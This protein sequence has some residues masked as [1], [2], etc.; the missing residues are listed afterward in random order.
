M[1]GVAAR[2]YGARRLTCDVDCLP[3]AS[4]ENLDRL[5][6]AMRELNARLRVERLGDEEWALLPI[7]LTGS[8]LIRLEIS[9]WR[10]DAGDL[11]ILADIP[12]PQGRHLAYEDLRAGA[13]ELNLHGT[14]VRVAALDDVIASKEWSNRPKDGDALPELRALRPE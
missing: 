12:G 10:T 7:R 13:S 5:A 6:A 3:K 1:G 2:A 11:D 4:P 9:T 8:T 14:V